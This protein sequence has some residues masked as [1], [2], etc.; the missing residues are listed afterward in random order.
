MKDFFRKI[1]KERKK[2]YVTEGIDGYDW[3]E[4]QPKWPITR[5]MN[6]AFCIIS[7]IV[8]VLILTRIFASGNSEYEKMILLNDKAAAVYPEKT[9]QVL[10]INSA[11]K[12]DAS[13]GVLVH[14]PVYLEEVENLQL[15]VRINHRTLKP[16][17]GKLGYTF[18]IRESSGEE[19]RFYPLSYHSI[20][21]QFQ[22]R[23]YRLCFEGV[24]LDP[25]KV[26]TLLLYRGDVKPTDG[27]YP[28]EK[29]DFRFTVL[30]SETYCNTVTPKKSVYEKLK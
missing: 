19:V 12:K 24:K 13:G 9:Q 6:T 15:T 11:N 20:E 10:R 22:Y 29:A 26:Y 4:S 21:K 27:A 5:I 25:E 23:F 8:W 16:G 28:A 1:F 30:N 14:Y 3:D 7:I 18:V 2:K 17:S